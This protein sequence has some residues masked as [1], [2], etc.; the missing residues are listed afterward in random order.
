LDDLISEVHDLSHSMHSSRLEHLGL[1]CALKEL[2]SDISLRRRIKVTFQ[3][4]GKWGEVSPP[5]SLCFY[6]IAQEALNNVAKHSGAS[7]ARVVLT[8]AGQRLTMRIVDD[9]IGFNTRAASYGLGLTS[10]RERI[11]SVSGSLSLV[12]SPGNGTTILIQAP[13]S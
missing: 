1:E 6:R 11:L 12:S 10:I 8:G 2:C 13:A 5:V 7:L 4:D 9:G 3:R